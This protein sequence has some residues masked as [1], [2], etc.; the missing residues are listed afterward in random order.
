ML[1]QNKK[2]LLCSYLQRGKRYYL[3]IENK[4]IK[5]KLIYVSIYVNNMN[6]FVSVN[7]ITVVIFYSCKIYKFIK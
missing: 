6:N 2:G 4:I 5:V 3:K 1:I 7:N